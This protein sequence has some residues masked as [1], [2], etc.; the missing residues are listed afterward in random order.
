MTD[1]HGLPLIISA[2]SGAG[3]SSLLAALLAR[4]N[5][6]G[7]LRMSVSHTTRAPREG[8]TDHVSYHFVDRGQFEE[9]IS[10]GAF[11]EYARVF[12]N[13]YGTSREVVEQWL[14]EGHDVLLDIDW[15][16]ARR[17]REQTPGTVSIFILPPSLDILRERLEKRGLD[18]PEVIASRMSRA[19]DEIS[20][21]TEYDYLLFNDVFEQ[22]L[23]ELH[24]IIVACRMQCRRQA[25]AHEA[26]IAGMLAGMPPAAGTDG[27]PP[28]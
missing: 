21:Y 18:T 19:R 8:E 3:K 15:Q 27:M 5:L 26:R 12:G 13:Y 7:R 17:I 2:P 25:A 9:L 6:D 14:S 10:R 23:A 4:F 16:G 28:P 24:A 11:Y 20:H 22:A 1:C